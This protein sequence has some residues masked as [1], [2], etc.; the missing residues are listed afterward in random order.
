MGDPVGRSIGSTA[1]EFAGLMMNKSDTDTSL[2]S[3]FKSSQL[4]ALHVGLSIDLLLDAPRPPTFEPVAII[5]QTRPE[6]H[7]HFTIGHSDRAGNIRSIVS[8]SNGRSARKSKGPAGDLLDNI[9]IWQ[10]S[11]SRSSG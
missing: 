3:K 2:Y 1:S 6:V 8:G 4:I 7:V 5:L 11:W 10:F 9:Q